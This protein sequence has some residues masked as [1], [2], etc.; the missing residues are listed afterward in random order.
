[1]ATFDRTKEV[2]VKLPQPG[3]GKRQAEDY[4]EKMVRQKQRELPT[5]EQIQD[6]ITLIEFKARKKHEG[7]ES[8][9]RGYGYLSFHLNRDL[10]HVIVH[11]VKV[12][13][14]E[15]KRLILLREQDIYA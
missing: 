11:F 9:L 15:K 5:L 2:K 12:D 8:N 13:D 6:F 7:G 10:N 4:T 1:M 14:Q 3:Q